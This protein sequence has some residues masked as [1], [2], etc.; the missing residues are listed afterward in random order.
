VELRL[1]FE[2]GNL[3][4]VSRLVGDADDAIY[5]DIGGHAG[6]IPVE[7]GQLVWL[8]AIYDVDLTTYAYDPGYLTDL[9]GIAKEIM[10]AHLLPPRVRRP[11]RHRRRRAHRLSGRRGML[12]RS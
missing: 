1:L 12:E 10:D 9:K 5:T 7:L 6:D 2:A 4:D 8:N 11:L 3:P